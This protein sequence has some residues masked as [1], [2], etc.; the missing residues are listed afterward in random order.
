MDCQQGYSL[1]KLASPIIAA[2]AGL[3]GVALGGAI[4]S[5]SQSKER[6][7]ARVREKLDK[8]YSPLLGIRMQILAKSEVRQKVHRSAEAEWQ[9]LFKGIDSPE[10]KARITT[11]RGP[12]FKG[13]FDYSAE[14]LKN[15]LVPLYKQMAALFTANMQFAEE[16]TRKYFGTLVEFVELWNRQLQ[17]PMPPEVV[18]SLNQS[19]KNLYPF[20]EDLETQFRRL[21]KQLE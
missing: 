19:E 21:R 12:D 17:K 14:Q 18:L 5:W 9:A 3:G 20:Y 10:E 1:A 16:P 11:E 7:Q 6:Q 15:D 2:F 8:F 13:V 4:A